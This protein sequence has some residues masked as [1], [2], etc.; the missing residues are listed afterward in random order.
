M[1]ADFYRTNDYFNYSQKYRA[2]HL[3]GFLFQLDRPLLAELR[4]S[5]TFLGII[6]VS[7]A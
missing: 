3:R 6:L 5:A 1:T 7:R 4:P 2:P